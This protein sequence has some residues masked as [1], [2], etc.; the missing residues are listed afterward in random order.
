MNVIK[1]NHFLKQ[2]RNW[3]EHRFLHFTPGSP[4]TNT[5]APVFVGPVQEPGCLSDG[6]T[7]APKEMLLR[8]WAGLTWGP[9]LPLP[10]AIVQSCRPLHQPLL[11][12]PSPLCLP[13]MPP[14]AG[15]PAP[16]ANS[17]SIRLSIQ[18]TAV[19]PG[20]PSHLSWTF[21]S[22][23]EAKGAMPPAP[24]AQPCPPS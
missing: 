19:W 3:F 18:S 8:S 2:F 20:L 14:S 23:P 11:H 13:R 6:G 4:P 5:D 24:G 10:V 21:A 7:E 22:S 1:K 15:D 16:P 9:H 12:T 17:L